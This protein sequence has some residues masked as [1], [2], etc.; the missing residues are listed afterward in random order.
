MLALCAGCQPRCLPVCGVPLPQLRLGAGCP[1]RQADTA[2]RDIPCCHGSSGA[3]GE[4]G[5]SPVPLLL[6]CAP[7]AGG[8]VTVRPVMSEQ[9]CPG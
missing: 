7:S 9:R 8:T 4:R 6:R 2:G 5:G 1:G 3:P